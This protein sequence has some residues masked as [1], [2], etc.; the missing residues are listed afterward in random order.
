MMEVGDEDIDGSELEARYD[1]DTGAEF[2]GVEIIGTKPIEDGI[3]GF[4]ETVGV[5]TLIRDPLR[6]IGRLAFFDAHDT[7][8]VEG[9]EGTDRGGTDG[10]DFAA[11]CLGVTE[12][13]QESGF[14]EEGL[15][16]HVVFR[17]VVA[18]DGEEGACADM[19]ADGFFIDAFSTDGV[20]H[21]LGEMEAGS[22]CCD[23]TTVL[24]IDGLVTFKIDA[25]GLSVEIW[26]NRNAAAEFKHFGKRVSAVPGEFNDG[27]LALTLDQFCLE[28]DGLEFWIFSRVVEVEQ[29]GFPTLDISHDTFPTAGTG[30]G[31]IGRIFSRKHRLETEDLDV[32]TGR[33]LEME[34][35]RNDLRVVGNHQ[36]VLREK[37]REMVENGFRN[38]SVLIF[39][40]LGRIPFRERIFGDPVVWQVVVVFFDIDVRLHDFKILIC[41]CKFT[42]I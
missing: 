6:D 20:H 30:S 1:D 10:D 27:S 2:E 8:V 38:D 25:F 29:I 12:F 21:S 28:I 42:Q 15:A 39:Q 9:L 13:A 26:G 22:R 11:F 3:H 16:V 14:D 36:S 17:H 33:T 19:E 7:G 37:V 18:L 24:G 35:C 40:K 5:F 4:G 41:G 23:G 32:G 31:E 34:T